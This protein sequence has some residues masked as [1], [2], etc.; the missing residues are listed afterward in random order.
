VDVI[1]V[2]DRYI[3]VSADDELATEPGGH[4]HHGPGHRH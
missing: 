1:K 4:A 2:R 3:V